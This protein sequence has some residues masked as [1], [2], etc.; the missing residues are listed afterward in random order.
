MKHKKQ[1]LVKMQQRNWNH[2]NSEGNVKWCSNYGKQNA[3][4]SKKKSEHRLSN[5]QVISVLGLKQICAHTF[6]EALLTTAKSY[7][8]PKCPLTDK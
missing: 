3:A 6:I 5:H 7:K 1:V 8:Q 2:V 4:F